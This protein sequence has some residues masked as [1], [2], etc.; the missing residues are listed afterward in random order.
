MMPICF[1]E[2]TMQRND[3]MEYVRRGQFLVTIEAAD[4]QQEM[5]EVAERAAIRARRVK[6]ANKRNMMLRKI[7]R[8]G[9]PING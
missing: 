4:K 3:G 2:M 1:R 8:Y 5:D 7:R 6:I 9:A